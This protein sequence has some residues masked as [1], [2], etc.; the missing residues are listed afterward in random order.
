MNR[1]LLTGTPLHNN[2]AELWS[3]LNFLL[4]EIFNDL[5]VFESWFDA[6]EL[7]E[8]GGTE[9]VLVQEEEKKVI[10]TLREI[11]KPFMLRRIKTDVCLDIP[12]RKE[13]I[14]HAPLTELQHD[15][16]KAVLNRD[17]EALSKIEQEPLIIPEDGPSRPKRKCVSRNKCSSNYYDPYDTSNYHYSSDSKSLMPESPMSIGENNNFNWKASLAADK[18]INKIAAERELTEWSKYSDIN[19]R[20]RDFFI[21]LRFG[22]NSKSSNF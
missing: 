15:L 5:A 7:Q 19:I 14:V 17:L 6:K 3:L 16:Y 2:L 18:T 9:K 10:G 4:P 13:I 11:L 1:L 21:R 20:N 12:P 8:N 22:S